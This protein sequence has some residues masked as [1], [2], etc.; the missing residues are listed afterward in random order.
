MTKLNKKDI[1]LTKNQTPQVYLFSKMDKDLKKKLQTDFKINELDIEDIFTNTQLAKVEQRKEYLYVLLNFP[2]Y[3][4]IQNNLLTKEIHCLI[5]HDF[6]IL[7]DKNEYRH[8]LEFKKVEQSMKQKD[9]SNFEIFYEMLDFFVTKLFVL[10]NKI[11]QEIN[12]VESNLFDFT[13]SNDSLKDILVI[14]KN[15]IT[16][17]SILA[18][19]D[20]VILELQNKYRKFVDSMGIE[21]LDDSLDKIKKLNNTLEIFDKQTQLLTETNESLLSRSTNETIKVLTS[22]SLIM[23]PPT[24]LAGF[25]GMNVYFGFDP[26]AQSYMPLIIILFLIPF[27]SLIIYL[28]FKRKGLI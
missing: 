15:L 11:K 12:L 2:D 26:I 3:N 17:I 22:L 5:S 19:L 21:K 6:L 28:I 8:F 13:T 16:F 20:D 9:F 18:P 4:L 23:V 24:F 1:D 7:I 10:T 27:S 25:F 14:R